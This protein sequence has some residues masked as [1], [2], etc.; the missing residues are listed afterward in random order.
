MDYVL[1]M[2]FTAVTIYFL[3]KVDHLENAQKDNEAALTTIGN[4]IRGITTEP[5]YSDSVE[6]ESPEE[7]RKAEEKLKR[8]QEFDDRITRMKSELASTQPQAT[9]PYDAEILHPDI[10][11]LPH[12]TIKD[13]PTE[14]PD[15][16]Y[17]K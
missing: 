13:K 8:D 6:A 2:C 14:L 5:P 7:L 17:A 15:V 9:S 10:E 16:E 12:D 3:I 4:T 1:L 11:N